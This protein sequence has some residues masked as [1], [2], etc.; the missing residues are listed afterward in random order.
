MNNYLSTKIVKAEPMDHHTFLNK[1]KNQDV[2][3]D[4]EN[5]SGFFIQ[6]PDGYKSWC[7]SDEFSRTYRLVSGSEVDLINS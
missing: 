1:V 5:Q 4:Q 2:S 7:P 6:Y 3:V